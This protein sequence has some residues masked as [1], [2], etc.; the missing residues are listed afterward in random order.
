MISCYFRPT[1]NNSGQ[2]WKVEKLKTG[3]FSVLNPH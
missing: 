3:N 1:A 2:K